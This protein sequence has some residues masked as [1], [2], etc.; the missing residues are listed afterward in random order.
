VA[1]AKSA[2]FF[3]GGPIKLRGLVRERT[4]YRR[5]GMIEGLIAIV[6]VEKA[7]IPCEIPLALD[8][9]L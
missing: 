6:K 2:F 1:L 9:S 3:P 8:F 7:E 4:R 5:Q